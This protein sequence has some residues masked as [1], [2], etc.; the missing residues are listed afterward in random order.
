MAIN[1]KILFPE[2]LF[3]ILFF[4]FITFDVLNREIQFLAAEDY[5]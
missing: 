2:L 5:Y 1:I 3:F 4:S